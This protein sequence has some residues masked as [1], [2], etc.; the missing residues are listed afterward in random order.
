MSESGLGS[1]V[2]VSTPSRLSLFLDRAGL[3]GF[4][5]VSA[6]VLYTISWGWILIVRGSLWAHDWD[7]F[8][9]PEFAKFNNEDYGF[10][11]WTKYEIVLFQNA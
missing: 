8:A 4:P 2:A 7:G 11:P 1:P 9:I 6:I 3:Q 10:A 5:W